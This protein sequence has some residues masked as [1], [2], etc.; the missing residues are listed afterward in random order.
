MK[1]LFG[2]KASPS[3][4]HGA[5]LVLRIGVAALMLTHGWM[6]FNKLLTGDLAFADPIGI[7]STPSLILS[8][9]A[10]FLGS[11]FLIFGFQTRATTIVLM[12]N[13]LVIA[14]FAHA[15]DPFSK[16]EMP[17]LYF[18]IYMTLFFVGPGKYSID[19]R[20]SKTWP[21]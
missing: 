9:I 2:A 18:L 16:K 10:E 3:A 7:G 15:S 14:F 11:L 8:T 6:K 4:V 20:T 21:G 5:L 12:T 19:G 1:P 17:F 13:M